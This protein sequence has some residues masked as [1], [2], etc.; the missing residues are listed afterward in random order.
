MPD[1]HKPLLMEVTLCKRGAS[2][3]NAT[4][5]AARNNIL[6][7][8]QDVG[9]RGDLKEIVATEKILLKN[10]LEYHANDTLQI[11]SLKA[12]LTDLSI[13]EKNIHIVNDREAY[14]H[15]DRS[16]ERQQNRSQ[17]LPLDEAR[18][19]FNS[20]ATRLRD[21]NKGRASDQEKTIIT[22]RKQSIIHA[23]QLYRQQQARTLGVT[24]EKPPRAR[25]DVSARFKAC[26]AQCGITKDNPNYRIMMA[27]FEDEMKTRNPDKNPPPRPLAGKGAFSPNA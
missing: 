21:L 12:A 20:H 9:R 27:A 24:L 15:V 3:K 1:L 4:L 26:L 5:I 22:A 7:Y 25:S 8:V 16:H 19:A 2:P 13:A 23:N 18:Q 11:S 6:K 17:G 14:S 10:E